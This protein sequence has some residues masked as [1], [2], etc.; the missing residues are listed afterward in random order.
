MIWLPVIG[1]YADIDVYA[2]IL[3]YENLLN[4]RSKSAKNYIPTTAPNYSVPESLRLKSFENQIFS[5]APNDQVIILDTSRPELIHQ[6]TKD[7]QI[8]EIIDHHP[9]YEEYWRKRIGDRAIIEKIGAVATSIFE[10]WGECWDYSKIPPEIAKLLLAA[11]LDNTLNFNAEITTP[12]DHKAAQNLAK[13]INQPLEDFTA[14]YF[15]TVSRTIHDDLENALTKDIK[16]INI[17]KINQ[18]VTFGQLTLWEA[19]TIINEESNFHNIMQQ[20]TA[21]NWL[22]SIINISEK[23]NYILAS[24]PEITSYITDLLK[25]D[26]LHDWIITNQLYLRKEIIAKII[27]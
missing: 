23:R 17:P 7:E 27:A 19:S 22:V 26:S 5:L 25:A 6:F 1:K 10:W 3:A 8:L 21:P 18:E 12:R 11:I 24:S 13:I 15:D 9:G 2:S 14:W 16:T 4:Q 20:Q